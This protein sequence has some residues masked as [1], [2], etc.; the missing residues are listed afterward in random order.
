MREGAESRS[1][2]SA[3]LRPRP[4]SSSGH[5]ATG[6]TDVNARIPDH[7]ANRLR[8]YLDGYTSPRNKRLG[9]VDELPCRGTA[10]TFTVT[11]D[12]NTL[13]ADLGTAGLAVT[14]TGDKLTADQAR[15][16]ACQAWI[17]LRR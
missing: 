10:T 5:A 4:S 15:R 9:E 16:L 8:T 17:R 7:V 11:I 3:A 12:W 1:P 14:S 6:S 13:L 2:P